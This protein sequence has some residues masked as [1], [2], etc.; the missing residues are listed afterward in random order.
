MSELHQPSIEFRKSLEVQTTSIPGLLLLDLPVMDDD[1][2]WFKE[3]YNQE[4]MSAKG[5]PYFEAVQNNIGGILERIKLPKDHRKFMPY[6]EKK[7]AVSDS[8]I[9]V[10]E[11][12]LKQNMPE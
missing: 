7:P 9:V 3:N 11:N 10:I 1:R 6:Q 4:K 2:G 5:L 12:W 8:L